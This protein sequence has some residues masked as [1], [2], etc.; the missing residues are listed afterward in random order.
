M[1]IVHQQL[2]TVRAGF[3]PM[4][5]LFLF[6]RLQPGKALIEAPPPPHEAE[7]PVCITMQSM[8]MRN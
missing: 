2:T 6:P 1:P 5:S 3:L 4:I 8:V 7:P